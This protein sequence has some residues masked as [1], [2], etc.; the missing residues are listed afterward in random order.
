M[1][2]K[3]EKQGALPGPLA[4]GIAYVYRMRRRIA[5]FCV[6]AAALLFGYIGFFGNNGINMYVQKRAKGRA[7]AQHI[8]DL[9]QQNAR[10]QQQIQSLKTDPDAIEYEARQRLHYARPGEVIWTEPSAPS[11]TTPGQGG[12]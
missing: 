8:T 7:L 10:L 2:N 6:V 3:A 9:E 5:T 11:A 12:N 4:D 1:I